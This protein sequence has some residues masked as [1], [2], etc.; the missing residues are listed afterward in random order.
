MGKNK[1]L[2]KKT[3]K[4]SSKHD[5]SNY[6]LEKIKDLAKKVSHQQQ[7]VKA[8]AIEEMQ[9]RNTTSLTKQELRK[10]KKEKKEALRQFTLKKAQLQKKKNKQIKEEWD[11]IQE[12]LQNEMNEDDENNE[13]GLALQRMESLGWKVRSNIEAD[14]SL[15]DSSSRNKNGYRSKAREINDSNE[16]EDYSENSEDD[17]SNESSEDYE[18]D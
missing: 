12:S 15:L 11:K 2:T 9:E 10:L 17:N 7:L 13:N 8:K 5:K 16:N 14:S 6:E 18:S 3:H 1:S 4:A